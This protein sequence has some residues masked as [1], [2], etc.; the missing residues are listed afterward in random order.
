MTAQRD[1][2]AAVAVANG[3]YARLT[4][5]P[6]AVPDTDD[7]AALL[8]HQYGFDVVAATGHGGN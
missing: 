8:R 5:L 2:H 1:V 4:P 6:R 7:L 3:D